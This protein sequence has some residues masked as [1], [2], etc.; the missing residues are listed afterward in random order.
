[1]KPFKIN[2]NSW[3]YW[4]NQHMLNENQHWME[5]WEAKHSNF[6]SYWRATLFR[7]LWSVICGVVLLTMLGMMLVAVYMNPLQAL[8]VMLTVVAVIA[9][10]IGC[11]LANEY[12]EDRKESNPEPKTLIGKQYAAYKSKICPSVE[13]Q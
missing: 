3:H 8:Y 5:K 7:V 10:I 6:C 4:L 2:R 1:M 12:F 11:V 9:S 13:F